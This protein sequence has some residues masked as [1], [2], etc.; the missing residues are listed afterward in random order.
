MSGH[1]KWSDIRA[2]YDTPAHRARVEDEKRLMD[3]LTTLYELRKQRGVTQA[4]L[5]RA[6]AVSQPAVSKIERGDDPSV[7]TLQK[8]VA[9]LGGELHVSATFPDG[10]EINLD[11]VTSNNREALSV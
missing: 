7:S 2:R 10:Q 6:L 1:R 11:V 4:D 3:A 9:A 8:Y 5:A